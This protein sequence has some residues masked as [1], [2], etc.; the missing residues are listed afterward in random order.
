VRRAP[1]REAERVRRAP[2]REAERVRRAPG[3]E[4]ERVRRAA[5]REGDGVRRGVR[6]GIRK[7]LVWDAREGCRS[8]GSDS[9]RCGMPN[10]I[11][12][13]QQAWEL[14]CC[15]AITSDVLWKLDA[16]RAA[17]FLLHVSRSDCKAL[18][19][20]RPDEKVASQLMNAAA[21]ISASLAEG[22]SRATRAD[23]LRFLGYALGSTRE[24]I[25]WFEAARGVLPDSVID[26]RL[27]LVMRL[28]A[29]LLGVIRSLRGKDDGP[30]RFER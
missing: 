13:E 4:A 26:A 23:R 30:T 17:L 19:A 15:P 12:D 22:Y 6:R 3:R 2:G 16:Y 8:A 21:S 9:Q 27:V 7:C 10:R 1:G 14:A 20:A 5:R 18:R 29:L 24:C 11:S 28:R 25:P